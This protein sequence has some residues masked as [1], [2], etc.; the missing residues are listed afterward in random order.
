MLAPMNNARQTS[1][2]KFGHAGAPS[3]IKWGHSR[4]FSGMARRMAESTLTRTDL[5]LRFT[6]YRETPTES[7]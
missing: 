2:R 3:H 4:E 5:G 6:Q 1:G 7:A